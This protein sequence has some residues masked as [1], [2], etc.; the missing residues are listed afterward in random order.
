MDSKTESSG[1]N[2]HVLGSNFAFAGMLSVIGDDGG[3]SGKTRLVLT[4][5]D[6]ISQVAS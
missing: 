4:I 6:T 3:E 1:D 5:R 2:V